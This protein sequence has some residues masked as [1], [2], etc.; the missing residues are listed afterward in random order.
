[1]DGAKIHTIR[2]NYDY[3]KRY[4]GK[5]R[6]FR[7]WTGRPYRSPQ[8][9]FCRSRIGVQPL[10]VFVQGDLPVVLLFGGILWRLLKT[11]GIVVLMK[12]L[13]K[14]TGSV[15]NANFK[16]GSRILKPVLTT[17]LF[18]TGRI[19][20]IRLYTTLTCFPASEALFPASGGTGQEAVPPDAGIL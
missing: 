19:S 15:K 20:G 6:S 18:F 1:L 7:V 9:E 17:S 8:R 4:D 12:T 10:L 13:Q 2:T 3:W 11:S 5:E 14:T 16:S